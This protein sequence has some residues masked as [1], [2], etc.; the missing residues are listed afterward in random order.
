MNATV[1]FHVFQYSA[2]R[3]GGRMRLATHLLTNR[4]TF[5]GAFLLA[6]VLPEL[7][8]PIF[9]GGPWLDI[10][11]TFEPS[12]LVA[13]L[14]LIVAHVGMRKVGQ[15]PLIDDRLLIFPTFLFAFTAGSLALA[16]I[17]RDVG[18]YHMLAGGL[19]GVS[20]Y[21][22]IAILANRVKDPCLAFVGDA[23]QAV[24]LLGERISWI[25]LDQPSLPPGVVGIVF[26]AH[27]EASPE[28]ERLFARAVLRNI[29][30]YDLFDLREMMTGRVRLR[31]RPELVF[32]QLMP[33]LPYLRLKRVL[34]TVIAVPALVLASPILVIAALAIRLESPGPALF[35]Q[36]RIGYQ[37]RVFNCYKLRSMRASLP[38]P[39]YT[40]EH[41]PRIT[42]IGRFIRKWRIDEL[43]Q[44]VNIIKGQ[45]SWIG[46]RP[47]A[48]S[49]ASQYKREI[50]YYAYRHAVRPG[51]SG[52]AAVHQGNV[53]LTDAATEKLEYDFY[54]I[55]HFSVW[56]DIL[57]T[58]MTVRTVLTGFG[59]R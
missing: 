6:I 16:W 50:P 46:P 20:W 42:R 8:H 38:G 22:F 28:W 23:S 57:I 48:R 15:L 21:L 14:C 30:V 44:I 32:G 49:L 12:I 52:W 5:A 9:L 36:R 27:Q 17:V 55:K 33:S 10:V 40:T 18:R 43:P 47:E 29:P 54:Y 1:P 35:V 2:Q 31:S 25:S 56:L 24:R 11:L 4:Y 3:P 34:D 51:I 13:T 53:A 39:A 59:S 26:D 37:G 19:I 41:D 58:L 45:M 7:F